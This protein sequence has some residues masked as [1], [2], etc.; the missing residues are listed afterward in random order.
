MEGE[1]M[2]KVRYNI[3][4]PSK[5]EGILEGLANQDEVSK[6]EVIRRAIVLYDY[7]SREAIQKDNKIVIKDKNNEEKE[8]VLT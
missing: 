7:L 1:P 4:L 8:I 6:A 3:A 5:F 2:A